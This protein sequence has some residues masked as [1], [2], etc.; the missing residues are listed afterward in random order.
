[1]Y[2]RFIL[3]CIVTALSDTPVIFL[4]GARQTGKSTLV[5]RIADEFYPARYI[6]LD[7]AGTLSAASADPHG[8][9]AGIEKPVVIDEVQRIPELLLSIKEDVDIHRQPGRYIL[10]GSADILAVP[11][12]A[13]ALAGR[14]EVMTLWPLSAAEINGNPFNLVDALFSKDFQNGL[15]QNSSFDLD[16]AM[17]AGGFPEPLQRVDPRRRQAWFDSYLTTI[18]D[19]EIRDLAHIQ[20]LAAVPRLLNLL[21]ARSA[22][23]HNQ[24]E[25]S[26]SSGISNSTLSR[27]MALLK[28][29]FLIQELPAWSANLGKRL[30]KSPK[31]FMVD[32]GLACSLIG[33][34]EN[35]LQ[36][37]GEIAGRMFENFVAL[38]LFKH[39][40]WSEKLVKLYHYRSQQGQEVD[41]VIENKQGAIVG[42]EVKR[43]GTP[44]PK[45]FSGLKAIKESLKEKFV[46]GVLVYTGNE[47]I[48]FEK[49]LHAIPI[50]HL[51]GGS[52][53]D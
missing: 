52:N 29:T 46:R 16:A 42:V 17:V 39:A 30:V 24:S 21:A 27:Y 12:V 34:E 2:R 43:S 50:Q 7:N 19:R 15:S 44:S 10:T 5:K 38:E 32:T 49:N 26:R 14:I 37:G 36:K 40:S 35:G 33:L 11:K 53:S 41:M 25:I 4:R 1:M 9:I 18:L 8:F 20:D 22:T 51:L 23:L 13:D 31:M 6:T 47:I 48:P 28:A 45:D 3:E